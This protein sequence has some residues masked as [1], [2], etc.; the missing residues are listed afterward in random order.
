M[1]AANPPAV[2]TADFLE[3][4][5]SSID[6]LTFENPY[7]L[8]ID[9]LPRAPGVRGHSIIG[10]VGH[11]PLETSS[12]GVI[13]YSSSHLEWVASEK[14]IN[15]HHFLQDDPQTIAELRR[16]LALHLAESDVGP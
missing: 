2:F 4:V 5:P 16:I 1:I 6:E 9:R 13:P 10:R 8:T 3:G 14:I 11:G 7:L 12:D 15:R